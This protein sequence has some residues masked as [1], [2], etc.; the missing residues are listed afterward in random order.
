MHVVLTDQAVER[1]GPSEDSAAPVAASIASVVANPDATE[2][3]PVS[4][5]YIPENPECGSAAPRVVAD[6]TITE[7][8]VGNGVDEF[9]N[10][11]FMDALR[12]KTLFG[13][14]SPEDVNV[15]EGYV[16][17]DDEDGHEDDDDDFESEV[18]SDSDFEDESGG[19]QQ[20]DTGMRE[21]AAAG[22]N[23][24]VKIAQVSPYFTE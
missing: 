14:V 3:E 1:S 15:I 12:V 11:H 24:I 10:D 7:T 16:E 23:I 6:E 8:N 9:D 20:D 21:L 4:S 13:H 5:A 17:E 22:W 18:E 2:E 19:F